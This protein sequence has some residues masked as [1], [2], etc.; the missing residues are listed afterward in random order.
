MSFLLFRPEHLRRIR[1]SE[2]LPAV[3][4]FSPEKNSV[5]L[6]VMIINVWSAC[7]SDNFAF[8]LSH[9]AARLFHPKL[10]PARTGKACPRAAGRPS[11]ALLRKRFLSASYSIPRISFVSWKISFAISIYSVLPLDSHCDTY[12]SQSASISISPEINCRQLALT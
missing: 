3:L 10:Q 9:I 6:F 12:S 4:P 2:P 11:L 7:F 8:L 5:F 1:L